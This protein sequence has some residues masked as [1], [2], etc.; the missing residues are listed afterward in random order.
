MKNGIMKKIN[1]IMVIFSIIFAGSLQAGEIG[2]ID[3]H[4]FISQGYMKSDENNFL[5]DTEDGTFEFNETGINFSTWVSPDLSIGMQLFASDLGQIGN[6]EIKLDWAFADY[7]WKDWAGLRIGKVK[8]PGGLYNE[9]RDLDMLRTSILLPQSVYLD[10]FREPQ[11]S[12]KGLCVYGDIELN[13]VGVISYQ[14]LYGTQEL[15]T[16]SGVARSVI[17]T[18]ADIGLNIEIDNFHV[19]EKYAASLQWDTPL[20]GLRLRATNNYTEMTTTMTIGGSSMTSDMEITSWVNSAEYTWEDLI[21]AVE[22]FYQTNEQKSVM[23][24]KKETAIGYYGSASYRFTDWF[25]LGMYYSEMY[26]DKDDKDGDRYNTAAKGYEDYR[27]WLKDACLSTRFDI[28]SNWIVKLEG[29]MMDGASTLN[30]LDHPGDM[31]SRFE[32]D[33]YLFAAKVSYMF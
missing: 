23:I 10:T 25:E 15:D 17:G 27:A 14:M 13:N 1:I 6:D 28:N 5:A 33:W 30:P 8:I 24:E 7:R 20:D 21:I 2:E 16:D 3:I 31:G 12:M 19:D 11:V 22:Y 18:L 9:S 4:G 32:K 26:P 29:H